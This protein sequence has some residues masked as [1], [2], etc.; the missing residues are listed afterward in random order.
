MHGVA[1]GPGGIA[2]GNGADS[3][4]GEAGGAA[5]AGDDDSHG[6]AGPI[7]KVKA[8]RA[9]REKDVN[10]KLEPLLSRCSHMIEA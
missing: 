4:A 1:A 6:A 2:G 3:R 8:D 5:V 7:L 9:S 10:V